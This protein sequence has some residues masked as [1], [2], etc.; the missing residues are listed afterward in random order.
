ML[1]DRGADVNAKEGILH[2]KQHQQVVTR[3]WCRYYSIKGWTSTPKE[4]NMEMA[5]KEH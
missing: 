4:E 2:Y 1:L 3:R 5:Y